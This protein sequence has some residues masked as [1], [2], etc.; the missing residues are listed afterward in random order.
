MRKSRAKCFPCCN[1]FILYI[2][3]LKCCIVVPHG[4]TSFLSISFVNNY[5]ISFRRSVYNRKNLRFNFFDISRAGSGSYFLLPSKIFQI[6]CPICIF[7]KVN[8][9]PLHITMFNVASQS[10]VNGAY[11]QSVLSKV[12]GFEIRSLV[13]SRS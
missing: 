3:R 10:K 13:V 8:V 4:A 11:K 9:S 12:S 1:L 5:W 2:V 7:E 6:F